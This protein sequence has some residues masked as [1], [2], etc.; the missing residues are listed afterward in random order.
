ME[1]SRLR[2]PW[3]AISSAIRLLEH[4][5]SKFTLGPVKWKNQLSLFATMFIDTPVAV[6]LGI[7][8]TSFVMIDL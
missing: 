6:Y 7:S 2:S 3:Q 4:A 8:S 1:E 5:E